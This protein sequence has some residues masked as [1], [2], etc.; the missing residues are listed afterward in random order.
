M[1]GMEGMGFGVFELG[2]KEGSCVVG[3]GCVGGC[4]GCP[5]HLLPSPLPPSERGERAWSM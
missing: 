1:D 2:G 3:L 4:L 5:G